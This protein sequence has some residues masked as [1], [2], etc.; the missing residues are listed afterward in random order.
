MHK[1]ISE[2]YFLNSVVPT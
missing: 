1:H 2:Y